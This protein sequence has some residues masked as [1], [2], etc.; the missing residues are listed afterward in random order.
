MCFTVYTF[1]LKL[2]FY[3]WNESK[4]KNGLGMSGPKVNLYFNVPVV[5]QADVYMYIL[6]LVYNIQSINSER[7]VDTYIHLNWVRH[8]NLKYHPIV[9]HL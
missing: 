2:F 9:N 8:L 5:Q 4:V 7:N 3:S 6:F 1:L